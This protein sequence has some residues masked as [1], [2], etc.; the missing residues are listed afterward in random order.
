MSLVAGLSERERKEQ[1]AAALR[2]KA[3]REERARQ[4]RLP[5][6]LLAFIEYF[7][8]IL[9]PGRP[10]VPGWPVEALCLHLE[11]ITKGDLRDDDGNR[12]YPRTLKRL[13]AN[14]PPGFMKS[15]TLNVFWPAWEWGPMEMPWLRYVAFSYGAHLTQRDNQKFRD[16]ICSPEY[17]EMWGHVYKVTG[18]GKVK[19]TNDAQGFKFAS[20]VRGVG[21]G[22]RGD[23]VLFDDPHNVKEAESDPVRKS[24]VQWFR[25]GM[26]NR[27]NSM[28]ESVIVIIMQRVHEE[29]VSGAALEDGGWLHL[30][31]PF[32][33]EAAR[34][35]ATPFWEDP[36]TEE[37]EPAWEARF[38]APDMASFKRQIYLWAGQYQQRPAPRGGGIFKEDWWQTYEVPASRAYDFT[39]LFVLAGLDTAFKEK[40]EN[41]YSALTVWAVYD[42]EKTKR[43]RIMLVDGWKKRLP[44]HGVHVTR[45]QNERERDYLRRSMPQ[46]GLVEWVN[47]TCQ[48]R[49]VDRL[50]IEDSARG[51][52]VNAEIR[53][54]YGARNWGVHLVPAKGDK[55]ARAHSVVDLFTDGM[56]YAPGEWLCQE[57]GIAHCKACPDDTMTWRWRDWALGV[58]TDM[59]VFPKGAHDDIVDSATHALKH[60]REIGLA[61]RREERQLTEEMLA[62]ERPKPGVA[63]GYFA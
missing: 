16:L 21:T 26:Q 11:E 8:H 45:D 42:D 7:W 4:Q 28:E 29:D 59:S 46:W 54:L 22:E 62:R 39:P 18:D 63:Q 31:I 53:R 15:L 13:L 32:E 40:Q 43:R 61:I 2:E 37:G 27:L 1:L 50:V 47:F 3:L 10:F 55:V 57:H 44:L 19:V 5:G 33:Y 58:V 49:K 52:D 60:L 24:T 56:V 38:K 12:I 25:E 35:C 48:R 20:S 30:M 34:H 9:E 41:D 51:H 36:R 6:G 14:V 23:R 17:Q